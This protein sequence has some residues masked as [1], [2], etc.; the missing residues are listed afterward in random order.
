MPAIKNDGQPFDGPATGVVRVQSVI[1]LDLCSARLRFRVLLN[2]RRESARSRLL[3]LFR[4]IS[5]GV[6][7]YI[8]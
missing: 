1:S 5:Q 8:S 6:S 2:L 3:L 7:Y 4:D